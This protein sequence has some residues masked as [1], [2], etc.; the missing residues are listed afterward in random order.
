M[1][2][3]VFRITSIIFGYFNLAIA[4]MPI[5]AVAGGLGD[6]GKTIAEAIVELKRDKVFIISRKVGTQS[7]LCT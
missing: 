4:T 2:C 1:V 3:T 5:V 6:L 7:L